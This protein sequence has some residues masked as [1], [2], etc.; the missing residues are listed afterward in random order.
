MPSIPADKKEQ[1]THVV[2]GVCYGAEAYCVL[3]YDPNNNE[4]STTTDY[5]FLLNC[6]DGSSTNCVI[7][8]WP[9]SWWL[10]E[11]LL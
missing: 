8:K 4:D 3:T 5:S 2:V 7:L 11:S 1:A 6:S 10:V 9:T